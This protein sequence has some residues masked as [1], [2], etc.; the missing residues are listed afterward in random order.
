MLGNGLYERGAT[1]LLDLSERL[2]TALDDQQA[3]ETVRRL[4]LEGRIRT[5]S[6]FRMT[7]MA[8]S[9]GAEPQRGGDHPG[10]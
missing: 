9:E 7:L 3:I 2:A 1:T 6:G 10:A 5:L 4:L 8:K